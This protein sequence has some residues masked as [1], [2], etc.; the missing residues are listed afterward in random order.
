MEPHTL[1]EVGQKLGLS[2]ERVRQIERGAL[3]RMR[4]PAVA[5]G[6]HHALDSGHDHHDTAFRPGL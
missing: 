5:G 4:A 6:L 3:D 2:R 1:P